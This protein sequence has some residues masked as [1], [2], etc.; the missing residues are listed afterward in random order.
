MNDLQSYTLVITEK[1]DA[2]ARIASALDVDGKPRRMTNN[3]VSFYL[4][5]RNGDIVVVPARGH[6]YTVGNVKKGRG[7]YP[8]FEYAWIPLH[9][10]DPKAKNVR[11][12]IAGI[13]QLA[14]KAE[15]F[16]DACDFDM[17]GSIVGYNILK[18]ACNG[19]EMSSKRMKYSTLAKEDIEKAYLDLMPKLDFSL[20]EAGLARHEVD[21]LYGVNLSRALMSAAK[22]SSRAYATIS[23]GRVQG[24]TL[25]F[26]AV[27]ER[28][29]LSFVPSPYWFVKTVVG[30]GVSDLEVECEKKR[31]DV[32]EEAERVEKTCM[33][34]T[35][36]VVKIET[37]KLSQAPPPP[38]DLSSLQSEAYRL[39]GYTPMQT[40]RIAQRLYLD[41]LISYPRTSSQKLP[42]TIEYGVI[43]NNLLRDSE[44]RGCA[45][46][47]LTKTELKPQ[48]GKSDDPAHPAIYPS[49][50]LPEA[51][52]RKNE[53]NIWNL[54]VRR[55]M[56]AFGD[57]S[58][59]SNTK[60][61]ME[62]KGYL[63]QAS[64]VEIVGEGWMRYYKPYVRSLPKPLP[65]IKNGEIVKIKKMGVEE[66][67]TRPPLRYNPSTILKKMQKEEIGT[68]ATRAGIV[69]TLY[70]RKF[71]REK[72]IEATELGLQ[73]AEV[74]SE[75]CP[76]VTS[77]VLTRALEEKMAT[78]QQRKA[79]REN[80]VEEVIKTLKPILK[81]LKDNENEIGKHLNQAMGKARLEGRT[82]GNCPSCKTGRLLII[83]SKRTSKRFVGCTKY[84]EG[85]CKTSFPIPQFGSIKSSGTCRDCGWPKIRVLTK[86]KRQWRL[87]FNLQCPSKKSEGLY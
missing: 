77:S 72:S 21:W 59:T 79:T 32:K 23:T 33:S 60:A 1:P 34:K 16:I 75:N 63:F 15:T 49:G 37:S 66:M 18:F 68:K 58:T 11:L 78:I 52:T 69:Q 9:E 87:C 83:R 54:V 46:S 25:R 8:V 24:P 6:L 81:K 41:A 26:I 38:F 51:S 67:F 48:E 45:A 12:W 20:I 71:I 13:S 65:L 40:S 82:L 27:R 84:F 70:D 29:I 43:L 86:G 22:R 76:S 36:R 7:I 61:T 80:V 64:G 73:V 74:L 44:H 55:F 4:A 62:V 2:A 50:N 39:F 5:K 10:A 28:N 47:L 42:P 85:K 30:I 31:F 17:E 53:R 14:E 3:A 35:G 56:A 19:K 57:S